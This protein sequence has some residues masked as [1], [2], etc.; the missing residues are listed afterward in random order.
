MRLLFLISLLPTILI[1]QN[2]FDVITVKYSANT[3]SPIVSES[4]PYIENVYA[5]TNYFSVGFN[6]Y[7]WNNFIKYSA[8]LNMPI[9]T[10]AINTQN[11]PYYYRQMNLGFNVGLSWV[12]D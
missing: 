8:G 9:N 5:A 1:A 4:F 11:E 10:I 7:I 6:Y 12:L 3:K 2:E